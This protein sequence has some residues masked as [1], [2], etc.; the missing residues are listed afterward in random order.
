MN[1]GMLGYAHVHA[2]GYAQSVN[3]LPGSKLVAVSDSD[4]RRRLSAV[5]RHGGDGCADYR[6]LLARADVEAVIVMSETAHHRELVSAAAAAGKHVI[7]EKPIATNL[8]D[9]QA[10]VDACR[11]HGVKLQALF[12]MRFSRPAIELRRMV[13]NGAVG[14]PLAVK[15]TNP[16]RVGPGWFADPILAGGGAVID[17]TVHVADMLRWIFDEEIVQVYAEIDTRLH[18]G[19]PVDDVGVL[20]LTMG[21]GLTASLDA[22]WSRPENWPTWGGLTFD[23]IGDRGVLAMD[24]GVE[25]L[26]V[27]VDRQPP[28]SFL[29]WGSDPGAPLLQAF[30]DAVRNDTETP[31][32]GE[33]G[34]RALEVALCAYESARRLAPVSCPLGGAGPVAETNRA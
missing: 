18:P 26:S 27:V 19:L 11:A 5:A 3:Q 8:V 29:E 22:S 7:C 13:R 4:E 34:L 21:S 2:A 17:H 28:Y 24:V 10:I 25:R 32:T 31:V 6:T 1:F 15:A 23:V 16:G 20:M 14:T 9:G 33:D 12:P 30:I